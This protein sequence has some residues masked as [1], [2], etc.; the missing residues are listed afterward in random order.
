[1]FLQLMSLN[2]CA[3]APPVSRTA[4]IEWKLDPQLPI[5]GTAIGILGSGAS[6]AKQCLKD[7]KSQL[8]VYAAIAVSSSF[9]LISREG[10]MEHCLGLEQGCGFEIPGY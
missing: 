8:L 3:R 10:A 5:P 2:P 6:A 7:H 1:M 9:L 4:P